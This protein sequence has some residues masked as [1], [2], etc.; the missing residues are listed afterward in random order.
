MRI[1]HNPV[2]CQRG[3]ESIQ[4]VMIMAVGALVLITVHQLYQRVSPGILDSIRAV[5]AGRSSGTG[6]GGAS[7]IALGG[8]PTRKPGGRPVGGDPPPKGERKPEDWLGNPTG[9]MPKVLVDISNDIRKEIANELKQHLDVT[10]PTEA[11]YL[12]GVIDDL[13]KARDKLDPFSPGHRALEDEISALRRLTHQDLA[14]MMQGLEGRLAINESMS[15]VLRSLGAMFGIDS[16]LDQD[17]KTQ[18]IANNPNATLEEAYQAYVNTFQ[19]SGGVLT[20]GVID[21]VTRGGTK[22]GRVSEVLSSVGGQ[23][24]IGL[25]AD[26]AGAA[27]AQRAFPTFN[28]MSHWLY[29]NGYSPKPPRFPRDWVPPKAVE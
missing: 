1:L 3:N 27:I 13:V 16:M 14:N 22:P 26:R 29:D 6:D 20:D 17:R 28:A 21:A 5:L 9:E 8:R 10:L 7:G 25:A 2:R 23:L 19:V 18:A 11:A 12:E 4:T 15:P 24:G